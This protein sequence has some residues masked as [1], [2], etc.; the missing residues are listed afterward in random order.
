M[1]LLLIAQAQNF[2]GSDLLRVDWSDTQ[3]QNELVNS[4][5]SALNALGENSHYDY[6]CAVSGSSFRTSFS[7]P[8]V[9]RWNHAHSHSRRNQATNQNPP[10]PDCGLRSRKFWS[11]HRRVSKASN[12]ANLAVYEAAG[13]IA[14]TKPS[15]T[16]G[17]LQ[18]SFA[19]KSW[20][21]MPRRYLWS[22]VSTATE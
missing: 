9:R 19:A 7:M 3:R 13:F 2:M 6:V 18:P 20:N 8:T 10:T 1:S 21:R 16:S 11:R 4:V 17:R 12:D 5:A 22:A 14:R 15:R